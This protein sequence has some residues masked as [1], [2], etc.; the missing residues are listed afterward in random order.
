MKCGSMRQ[1]L[2]DLSIK[3]VD[4]KKKLKMVK[5]KLTALMNQTFSSLYR[6]LAIW[7]PLKLQITKKRAKLMIFGIWV[8]ALSSTIP[9]ALFF[10]LVSVYPEAPE[11]KLCIE[12]WPPGTNG[13]LY[14]LLANLVACYL[15]PMAL[16][17]I[18]YI[19]IWIK[20]M[21]TVICLNS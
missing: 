17:S 8:I 18:C 21:V 2:V 15:L 10:D 12:V 19:L 11:I 1:N 3:I 13:S 20:V 7:W 4:Q 14:F 6:F 9:W 5:F 16:I